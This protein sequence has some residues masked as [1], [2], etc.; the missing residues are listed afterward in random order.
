MIKSTS[1]ITFAYT[2]V[3]AHL[4][5]RQGV[6]TGVRHANCCASRLSGEMCS[7]WGCCFRRPKIAGLGN[8]SL[9]IH[10]LHMIG[11]PGPAKNPKIDNSCFYTQKLCF[12]TLGTVLTIVLP[13]TFCKIDQVGRHNFKYF[14]NFFEKFN[15]FF[16]EF[17]TELISEKIF[18]PLTLMLKNCS[19]GEEVNIK[20]VISR[21][22]QPKRVSFHP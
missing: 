4:L 6:V 16:H 10:I 9:D 14:R 1:R 11:A 22:T 17:Y 3:S 20:N 12:I 21:E 8:G 15:D 18:G 7:P 19:I 2:P 13:A 5:F